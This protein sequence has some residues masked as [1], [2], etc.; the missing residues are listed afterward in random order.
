MSGFS[1]EGIGKQPEII[2]PVDKLSDLASLSP[3]EGQL[4]WVIKRQRFFLYANGDWRSTRITDPS[5]VS[6]SLA[7]SSSGDDD[8]PGTLADP[9][10]TIAEFNARIGDSPIEQLTLTV[11]D[12]LNEDE[13]SI[14]GN[15]GDKLNRWIW[16]VGTPTVSLTTTISQLVAWNLDASNN[17]VGTIKGTSS[18]SP[19]AGTNHLPGNIWR[20]SGGIRD[21]AYGVFGQDEGSNALLMTPLIS[22]L[23]F[24]DT[25]IP[26]VSDT[27]QV[28]SLPTLTNKLN[29][30]HN[31]TLFIDNLSFGSDEHSISV[32]TGSYLYAS[33][34]QIIGGLD[35]LPSGWTEL[36][37]CGCS[38]SLRLEGGG[39]GG[40][41]SYLNVVGCYTQHIT[42]RPGGILNISNSIINQNLTIESYSFGQI[43]SG[44]LFANN[45]SPDNAI[46]VGS[47]ALFDINGYLNGRGCSGTTGRI[48]LATGGRLNYA[49]KPNITG[50][51]NE[52]YAA[53][54]TGNFSA[55][56]AATS[57]GTYISLRTI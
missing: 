25:V 48:I 28:L 6:A 18:L 1:S 51:G 56:P 2:P 16:L 21:G 27:I 38:N 31:C 33:G 30:G 32:G 11:L 50:T 8:A 49:I 13:T 7:I 34:C 55:L 36:T 26:Q 4:C 52:W 22:A 37:A 45:T 47:A 44:F 53:G 40:G 20:I 42:C 12:S 39:T 17:T 23:Y 29:V 15:C 14:V 9:I 54:T 10:K 3:H 19:Y 35:V 57:N 43:T 46:T 41:G 24:T 5:F